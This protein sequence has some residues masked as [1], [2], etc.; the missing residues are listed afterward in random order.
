[1]ASDTPSSGHQGDIAASPR[2]PKPFQSQWC[3][4]GRTLP[5]KRCN[6][7]LRCQIWHGY[8]SPKRARCQIWHGK[9][10]EPNW[11]DIWQSCDGCILVQGQGQDL[12][13]ERG[14]L[15]CVRAQCTGRGAG[16][17]G[18]RKLFFSSVESCLTFA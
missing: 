9:M 12:R 5:P 10:T 17:T 15:I 8:S 16:P 2:R 4:D 3:V 14:S 18:A 1:M 13:R 6:S 11:W 7:R